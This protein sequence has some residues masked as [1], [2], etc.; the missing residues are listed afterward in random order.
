MSGR[1]SLCL[2][3]TAYQFHG[4]SLVPLSLHQEIDNLAFTVDRSPEPGPPAR[5]R[6][7]HLIEMPARRWPLASTAKFAGEQWPLQDPSPHHRGAMIIAWLC[8]QSKGRP[9]PEGRSQAS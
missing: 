6:H 7:G 2:E 4:C 1:E 8:R 3:Q 9:G 5:N